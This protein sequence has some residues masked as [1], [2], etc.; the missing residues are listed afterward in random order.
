MR[1]AAV[2]LVLTTG[3]TPLT[4]VVP[5]HLGPPASPAVDFIRGVPTKTIESVFVEAMI[6]RMEGLEQA[7]GIPFSGQPAIQVLDEKQSKAGMSYYDTASCTIQLQQD[8]G[9]KLS[10]Y[11]HK[12]V[13]SMNEL[14]VALAPEFSCVVDH[15]LGHALTDQ[16]SRRNGLGPWF[17]K[18][19]YNRQD[20]NNKVGL[21]VIDE[22]IAYYFRMVYHNGE[23]GTLELFPLYGRKFGSKANKEM[24]GHWIVKDIIDKY[25]EKGILW[26][27]TH[28]FNAKDRNMREEARLYRDRA[29]REL[30][31]SRGSEKIRG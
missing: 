27:I 12:E 7:K 1:I 25:G 21:H 20:P 2:A 23:N 19:Y 24:A 17:T 28:P 8:I 26:L 6:V 14:N 31:A 13:C 11:Y 30:E 3:F 22:G 29:L 10:T 18:E 5:T 16:I 9:Q 4:A 15:E